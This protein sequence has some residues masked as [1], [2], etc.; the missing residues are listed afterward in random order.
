[1]SGCGVSGYGMS[2]IAGKP[3]T[4]FLEAAR[5]AHR[6]EKARRDQTGSRL[7]EPD[8]A[9]EAQVRESTPAI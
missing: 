6:P 8:Q 7:P 1:M 2:D 4:E 5:R 3:L 9:P